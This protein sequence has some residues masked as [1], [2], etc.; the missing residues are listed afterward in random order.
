VLVSW[1]YNRTDGSLLPVFLVHFA[2]NF[3]GN[4]AGVF[5]HTPLFRLLAGICSVGAVVAVALDWARFTR[6][7]AA[8]ARESRSGLQPDALRRESRP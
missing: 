3:I 4:A 6:P 5:G 2:F 8:S 7:A 1:T